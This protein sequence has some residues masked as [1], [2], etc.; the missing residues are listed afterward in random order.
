MVES[1]IVRLL[2]NLVLCVLW[3]ASA[4]DGFTSLSQQS[5]VSKCDPIEVTKMHQLS[6]FKEFRI[7]Q[8]R[9]SS[10]DNSE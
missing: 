7:S 4:C 5:S 8:E 9:Y 3:G 10:S 2:V 1:G 6:F